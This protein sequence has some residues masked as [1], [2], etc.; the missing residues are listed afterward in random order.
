[1]NEERRT[2]MYLLFASVVSVFSALLIL[3][4]IAMSWESWMVPLIFIG[5]FVVWMVHITRIAL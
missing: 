5:C 2:G 4:T 1:M 3:I